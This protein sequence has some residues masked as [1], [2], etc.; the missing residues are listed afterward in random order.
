[1]SVKFEVEHH[2]QAITTIYAGHSRMILLVM[3]KLRFFFYSIVQ[4]TLI[5]LQKYIMHLPTNSSLQNLLACKTNSL[6]LKDPEKGNKKVRL[7]TQIKQKD[8]KNAHG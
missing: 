3:R 6:I 4:S 1:M 8:K 7:Q 2:N 5:E